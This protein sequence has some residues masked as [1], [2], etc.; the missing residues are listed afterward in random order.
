MSVNY[1][2]IYQLRLASN[3]NTWPNSATFTCLQPLPFPMLQSTAVPDTLYIASTSVQ[4]STE[5][6]PS[7]TSANHVILRTLL[8]PL[9]LIDS[10]DPIFRQYSAFAFKYSFS[11]SVNLVAYMTAVLQLA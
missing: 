5:R 10:G 8:E 2:L 3:T 7:D 6:G 9:Q 11:M 1:L 4:H